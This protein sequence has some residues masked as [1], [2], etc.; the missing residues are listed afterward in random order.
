MTRTIVCD[1][2]PT[3]SASNRRRHRSARPWFRF[4]DINPLTQTPYACSS[5]WDL[6][7]LI[8]VLIRDDLQ[9]TAGSWACLLAQGGI[10]DKVGPW[11][12]RIPFTL[13]VTVDATT[14]AYRR[15]GRPPDGVCGNC[16]GTGI[17]VDDDTSMT[18]ITNAL[19]V[20]SCM[21]AWL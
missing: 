11:R 12:F 17:E 9:I 14:V 18:G 6:P 7:Y 10:L 8:R 2:R 21:G 19:Y 16:W 13:D 5:W 15:C 3:S 4:T 20:C 1:R